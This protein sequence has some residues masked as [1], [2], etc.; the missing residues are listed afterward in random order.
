MTE[1]IQPFI[2]KTAS[3]FQ[4]I[5]P[6]ICGVGCVWFCFNMSFTFTGLVFVLL[7]A[8]IWVHW[9]IGIVLHFSVP[10]KQDTWINSLLYVLVSI[11][12]LASTLFFYNPIYYYL[13]MSA[14]FAGVLPLILQ[15]QINTTRVRIYYQHKL[16]IDLVAAVSFGLNAVLLIFHVFPEWMI[17]LTTLIGHCVIIIDIIVYRVYQFRER[18]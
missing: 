5:N 6:F 15:M 2:N 13:L 11:L 7:V 12:V 1:F 3:F 4:R 8:S 18:V 10:K 14:A 9:A 16:I 17:H